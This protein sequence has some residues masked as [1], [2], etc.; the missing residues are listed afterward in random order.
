MKFLFI[1]I[2]TL[3]TIS[4]AVSKPRISITIDDPHIRQTPLYDPYTRNRMILD[5][6]DKFDLKAALFVCGMRVDSDSGRVLIDTWNNAGHMICNHSYSHLYYPSKKITTEVFAEDFYRGDSIVNGYSGFKK[7]FRFPYLKEGSDSVK[8]DIMRNVLL[9]N[10]YK[11]G[12]VSIDASDW[13]IDQRMSERLGADPNADLTGYG[14]FYLVHIKERAEY[15][16]NL[17]MEVIGRE[18]DHVLLL[19]HNLLN[20]L[21]LDDI[22][23]MF[24]DNGWEVIDA[25]IAFEDPMYSESPDELPAGESIIWSLAYAT[26]KYDDVLRYPAED[27]EYEKEKMDKLGL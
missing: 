1:S 20:A 9:Q 16:N 5:N 24:I 21:F 7:L 11:N 19:H 26:G 14:D 22:I 12:N 25:M 27:G 18:P 8:R 13:Y 6:L 23:Q 10:G 3:F 17:A 15:Y 2:L 4:T